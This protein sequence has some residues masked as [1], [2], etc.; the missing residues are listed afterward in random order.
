[1]ATEST[2]PRQTQG[3]LGWKERLAAGWNAAASLISTR[4]EIFQQELSEKTGFAARGAVA[5]ILG[6][7]FGWLAVLLFTALVASL[8]AL[9]FGHVWAGLLAAFVL[10]LAIAGAAVTL[11]V[12]SFSRVRPFH[13]PTT[14][15]ELKKDWSAIRRSASPDERVVPTPYRPPAPPPPIENLEERFRAGSAE[16]GE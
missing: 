8:L 2:D 10:Y 14:S 15:E 11:G 7:V 5:V 16:G 3:A 1:M 4:V 12:K 9:L 6:L 13:F